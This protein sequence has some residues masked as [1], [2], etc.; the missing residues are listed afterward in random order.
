MKKILIILMLFICF[1][2]GVYA[3]EANIAPGSKS[4]ILI[5]ASTGEIIYEN[6]KDSKFAPASMTKIMSLIL[7]MEE[8]ENGG[9]KWNE[10][11]QISKNASSMGGSQIYLEE[12]EKM[13]VKDLIKGICMASA[14]DAV[15]ALAERISGSEEAFVFKMNEKVKKLGLKNTHFKNAT[16]LDVVN[17]YSSAYD[18][19]RM[20]MELVKHQKVLEFSGTYEDYL[21]QNTKNK[22]WLV[23]TNKLIKKYDGMDGLKTGY[24]KEAG[25]CLTATAKKNGMRLIG[26]V[27]GEPTSSQRNDEMSKILD[28]GFNLYK[29]NNLVNEKT[30]LAKYENDKMKI[31]NINVV[32]TR[33]VNILNK[34]GS[35]KR[36]ITYKIKINRKK[37]PIKKG[38]KVGIMK[39]YEN[40]KNIYDI[41]L[42]VDKNVERANILEIYI[43]NIGQIFRG[44]Y[45]N[46]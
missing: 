20:A 29:V 11:I 30:K 31:S 10:E 19:S 46:K 42:T 17:H 18:M 28:Y 21:R 33:D 4:T 22:F 35:P 27:M 40:N 16:G 14:N 24:T 38:M 7:I 9:L 41:D 6:N 5:E 32:S 8:I 13:I 36:N 39:V 2:E 23:N 37:L 34:K 25:Y 3:E 45:L 43:K 44:K 12:G 15:V 1:F 26:V